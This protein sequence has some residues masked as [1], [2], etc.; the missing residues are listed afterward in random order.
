M[1]I[2]QKLRSVR[3]VFGDAGY[4]NLE[5]KLEDMNEQIEALISEQGNMLEQ[6]QVVAT[7]GRLRWVL[8]HGEGL[9]AVLLVFVGALFLL[10][11]SYARGF[12][13]DI[14][15]PRYMIVLT[16]FD[17][18]LSGLR[19][20]FSLLIP[21]MLVLGVSWVLIMVFRWVFFRIR[22][23]SSTTPQ[24]FSFMIPLPSG[25][26]LQVPVLLLAIWLLALPI[27]FRVGQ[28]EAAQYIRRP[29]L[30]DLV[31]SAPLEISSPLTSTDRSGV[32]TYREMRLITYCNGHY[33]VFDGGTPGSEPLRVYAI[34][35]NALFSVKFHDPGKTPWPYEKF[36]PAVLKLP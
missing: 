5:E 13:S 26:W 32:T 18:Q 36:V 12:F 3:I 20:F 9:L 23:S 19:A 22:N 24:D 2:L 31:T 7:K 10:G 17:L 33:F 29:Q 16:D 14:G 1:N 27:V 25:P 28:I 15:L 4:Q 21:T 6:L 34:P 30:V 35:D 8:E 11:E